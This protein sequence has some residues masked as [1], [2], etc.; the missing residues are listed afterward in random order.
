MFRRSCAV[1]VC[2]CAAG[3]PT[4]LTPC[5]APVRLLTFSGGPPCPVPTCGNMRTASL[6]PSLQSSGQIMRL[7]ASPLC[8]R[9]RSSAPA[10]SFMSTQPNLLQKS[11]TG[12]RRG[13][14]VAALERARCRCFLP[15][16]LTREDCSGSKR[17]LSQRTPLRALWPPRAV[18]PW[19]ACC[20][21]RSSSVVSAGISR[22]TPGSARPEPKGRCRYLTGLLPT[23]PTT[24]WPRGRWPCRTGGRGAVVTQCLHRHPSRA[25]HLTQPASGHRLLHATLEPDPRRRVKEHPRL[26]A[27]QAC[28]A[29]RSSNG[30]G[31]TSVEAPVGG[32]PARGVSGC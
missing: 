5:T 25:R 15:G 18:S 19:K 27:V 23:G 6:G 31:S 8:K 3:V 30:L 2:R 24:H 7:P 1:R 13:R 10:V 14:G 28:P 21:A 26:E 32:E 16:H 22:Y 29:G 9:M 17:S 11:G 12:L 20:E 4:M